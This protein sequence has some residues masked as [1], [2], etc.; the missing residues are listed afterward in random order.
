MSSVELVLAATGLGLASTGAQVFLLRD[1]LVSAAGDE[2]SIG[3]GLSSWLCGI[4]VGAILARRLSSDRAGRLSPFLLAA[5]SLSGGT[6]AIVGRLLRAA[7]APSAGE[8]PGLGL[9]FVLAG[10]TLLPAGLL[11]G[12]AF[13]ALGAIAGRV[14]NEA[15]DDVLT[16]IYAFE[17]LG[18]LVSG[19]AAT[20]LVGVT[21]APLPAC[22]GAGLVAALLA[23]PL[24]NADR[25]GRRVLLGTAA[26]LAVAVLYSTSLDTASEKVR[27]RSISPGTPIAAVV[28]TP[29]AHLV[30][31]GDEVRH[32]YVNGRYSASFPDPYSCET[33][34]H[35]AATF[36]EHPRRVLSLGGVAHGP[37]RH[38]LL[39]GVE[40]LTLVEPDPAA[41]AFLE[42]HLPPEDQ[43]AL[44]DPRVRIVESDPRRFLNRSSG[45]YDLI[46]LLAPDPSTLGRARLTTTEFFREC[47]RRTDPRGTLVLSLRTAPAA[48]HG[49]TASLSATLFASL[50]RSYPVVRVTPGPESFFVA[51]FDPDA[52]SLDP[53]I[54]AERYRARGINSDGFAPE[55][56]AALLLPDRV[57][58]FG[59]AVKREAAASP[60]STDDRP[61][62]FAFA[63]A[64]AERETGSLAGKVLALATGLP[65]GLLAVLVLVPAALLA[66]RAWMRPPPLPTVAAWCVGMGGAS[67]MAWTLVLLLS[68]QIREGALYQALGLL[69]A[70]FMLGL[71][72]GAPLARTLSRRLEPA[73]RRA[74]LAAVAVAGI[75]GLGVS[76]AIPALSR[77]SGSPAALTL[78]AHA[79][80]LLAC[81]LV[82]GSLFPV[83]MSAF[84]ATEPGSLVAAGRFETADHAGAAVAA[85]VSTVI[86]V[87]GLGLTATAGLAALLMLIAT[88]AVARAR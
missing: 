52:V 76:W 21:V 31:A 23:L 33:A 19:I 62:S 65:S 71:A 88:A 25:P 20:F 32:L 9:T 27:F 12:S 58:A 59:S 77:L 28:D 38:L 72:T 13:S 24:A 42:D 86:L 87:P 30:L 17:S 22:L 73:P 18:S 29:L 3:I 54:L 70:S 48:L 85:L 47:A 53:A 55:L 6:A 2:A 4:A 43:K 78:A 60:P 5:V 37:L 51:G 75:T 83:A 45:V 36:A 84:L 1:L 34:A 35:L 69:T 81:G 10:A 50:R 57:M 16:R 44:G 63:L 79:V 8:L 15:P 41:F 67:G 56:F 40:T 26:G 68:F 61:A 14:P 7:L 74:L 82:T 39:H 11:V 49:E 66:L 46:L 64:R 80:L